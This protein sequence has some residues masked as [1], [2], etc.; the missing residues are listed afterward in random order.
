MV[1]RSIQHLVPLFLAIVLA[2]CS[3]SPPP[4][5]YVAAQG[6]EIFH[7]TSCEHAREI[8]PE[9]L[10]TFKTRDE[11]IKAGLRPCKVCNP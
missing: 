11:A 6:R 2:G 5:T 7:R 8:K 4:E 10:L 3:H 9:H 1:K